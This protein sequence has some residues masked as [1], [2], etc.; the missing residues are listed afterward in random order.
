MR[1]LT[2]TRSDASTRPD[3]N[4]MTFFPAEAMSP[5]VRSSSEFKSTKVMPPSSTAPVVPTASRTKI[6]TSHSRH[7]RMA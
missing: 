1:F 6:S 5:S 2:G 3:A 4:A 7:L